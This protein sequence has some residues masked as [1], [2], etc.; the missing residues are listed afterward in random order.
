MRPSP[1]TLLMHISH[2]PLQLPEIHIKLPIERVRKALRNVNSKPIVPT[3]QRGSSNTSKRESL[4]QRNHQ[5]ANQ[6]RDRRVRNVR[7]VRDN[8][9]RQR[10]GFLPCN[11]PSR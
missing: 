8:R 9:W 4:T 1:P 11:F 7:I 3:L 10:L 2:Q 6:R 5:R